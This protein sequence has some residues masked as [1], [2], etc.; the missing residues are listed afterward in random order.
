MT[1]SRTRA[2]KGLQKKKKVFFLFFLCQWFRVSGR[3]QVYV[4]SG[5]RVDRTR[6]QTRL[7]KLRTVSLLVTTLIYRRQQVLHQICRCLFIACF[8]VFKAAFDWGK[9]A[10]LPFN[11]LQLMSLQHVVALEEKVPKWRSRAK[12]PQS[13]SSS[14]AQKKSECEPPLHPLRSHLSCGAAMNASVVLA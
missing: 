5:Q 11:I 7:L 10:K 14:Q 9:K 2:H 8:F 4:I 12:R 13:L 3:K 1:T 6:L